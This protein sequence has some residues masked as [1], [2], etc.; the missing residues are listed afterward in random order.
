MNDGPA[1]LCLACPLLEKKLRTTGVY[2]TPGGAS[3]TS[4]ME[5]STRIDE[6]IRCRCGARTKARRNGR[7]PSRTRRPGSVASSA[8]RS[9]KSPAPM[10]TGTAAVTAASEKVTLSAFVRTES[11]MHG[12]DP[13]QCRGTARPRTAGESR[14]SCIL[15]CATATECPHNPPRIENRLCLST[16]R[17]FAAQPSGMPWGVPTLHPASMCWNGNAA[18]NAGGSEGNRKSLGEMC[19]RRR[20]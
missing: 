10:Q 12:V 2:D 5:P 17:C 13:C 18:A 7:L 19:Q 11:G 9:A 3:L 6:R 1:I 15:R 20:Y 4:Q 14:A 16:T 8:G